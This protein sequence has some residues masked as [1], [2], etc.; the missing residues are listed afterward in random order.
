MSFAADDH[1]TIRRRLEEIAAEKALAL[2]GST[3]PE[4][5]PEPAY[6]DYESFCG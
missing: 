3:I 4:K 1:E 6:V 2:T 5:Q